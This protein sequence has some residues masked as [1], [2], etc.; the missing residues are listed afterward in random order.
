MTTESERDRALA[1]LWR[2]RMA[3]ESWGSDETPEQFVQRIIHLAEG[4]MAGLR[5]E[6]QRAA[7]TDGTGASGDQRTQERRALQ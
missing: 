6:A 2:I 4:G 5:H 7:H 1:A 3:A